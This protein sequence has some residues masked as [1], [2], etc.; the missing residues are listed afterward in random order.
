[1]SQEEEGSFIRTVTKPYR[2]RPDDEMNLMGMLLGLGL[3]IVLI[4][5]LPFIALILLFSWLSELLAGP[6]QSQG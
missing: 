3:I 6:E 2:S 4:P 5:L 1:M